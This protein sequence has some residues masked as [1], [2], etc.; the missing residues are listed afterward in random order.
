MVTNT[1]QEKELLF[2]FAEG[3]SWRVLD[4]QGV[5]LPVG[6]ALV[7]F[8]IER[9]DDILFVEIKDPSHSQSPDKERKK[10][11]KRLTDG[12]VLSDEL[13]PKARDSYAHE[14]L[15][16]R[17]H[18]P[19]VYVVLLGLDAFE[20]EVQRAILN[21][22]SDRL[23]NSL[24]TEGEL[25]WVREHIKQCIVLSVDAWNQKFPEYRANRVEHQ[26]AITK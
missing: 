18:K 26:E 4:V 15:M 21:N 17:D 24:R 6:M 22:F 9:T 14:H 3:T 13:T 23:Y 5:R 8:V 20:H 19:I 11:L 25:P 2:T 12:S 10:Y 1:Y 7:D 16:G